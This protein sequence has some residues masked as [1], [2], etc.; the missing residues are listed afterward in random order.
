[1]LKDPALGSAVGGP[2]HHYLRMVKN[3]QRR[4]EIDVSI[5]TRFPVIGSRM[6]I[7]IP[8]A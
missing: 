8:P 6:V 5:W 4:G 2:F 7:G 3:V 1:M